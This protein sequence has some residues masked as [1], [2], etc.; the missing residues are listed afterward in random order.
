MLKASNMKA[1]ADQYSVPSEALLKTLKE[2]EES[3]SKGFYTVSVYHWQSE[4]KVGNVTDR[5][6][7]LLRKEGFKVK[8][9]DS[10]D[11]GIIGYNISW[12]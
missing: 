9:I 1:L 8:P 3:A 10:N 7:E 5:D 12:K 6:L 2:I 11:D 4:P